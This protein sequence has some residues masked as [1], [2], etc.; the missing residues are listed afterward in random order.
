MEVSILD[1]GF[2]T[3][4]IETFMSAV[5]ARSSM[6]ELSTPAKMARAAGGRTDKKTFENGDIG[7]TA[8]LKAFYISTS[9]RLYSVGITVKFYIVILNIIR[10]YE[11]S[12]LYGAYF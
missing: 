6:D 11:T 2:C 8:Q 7:R 12:F 3:G 4:K 10:I 9:F 1:T 5:L